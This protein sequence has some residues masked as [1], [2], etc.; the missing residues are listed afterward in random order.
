M[1]KKNKKQTR[2]AEVEPE[3]NTKN[4]ENDDSHNKKKLKKKRMR[5]KIPTVS[6]AVPASIIDNVPT[7]ELA[8]RLAGQIARAATI[9]RINEVV[10][11]DNKSNPDND[12]VLDNVGDESG[13]AFLM[14]ILQYLETP[15]YL[16]KALFPMHN[17]L[18]F[19]GLL[20]P[21]DAPHHLRKHE[22]FPYREGVTVKERDSNS[23]AT[24]VDVGLVKNVIVDQIFEPGRRVTVAM[25]TDRNLDSDLPRQVIS[26]SKPREEGTYW[27]YQVRYAHNISAVFKDCAY[28]RGYDFIIGTSEHGQIIKSSDLEIPSFRHLLIAFGGLAGLEES[29]EEDDN[30]KGKKAQDAFN[31]YLNTCPHQGS[32]TIR[33]EEAIFISLQYFQ[34][35]ISRAFQC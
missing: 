30:L 31:L 21:L 6:I 27:G 13:A 14:R 28:K 18:R 24:L 16:R 11:F 23:G 33:T 1:A 20:P 7:L 10:V 19:V 2:D 26:S 35:P 32:R 34:E 3:L 15:Q 9:F 17:S 22:W 29:I 12:S 25:G 5:K 8:T 4:G